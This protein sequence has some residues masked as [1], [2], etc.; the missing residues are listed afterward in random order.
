MITLKKTAA[1]PAGLRVLVTFFARAGCRLCGLWIYPNI[2]DIVA[3]KTHK[4]LNYLNR[5]LFSMLLELEN[6]IPFV[7]SSL[8][9][10]AAKKKKKSQRSAVTVCVELPPFLRCC[11]LT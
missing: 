2:Q 11:Y 10:K 1:S 7:S 4:L 3:G 6:E 5:I 8:S 9:W